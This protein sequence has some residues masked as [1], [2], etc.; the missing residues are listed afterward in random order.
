MTKANKDNLSLEQYIEA[1]NNETEP[2]KKAE[3]RF[4][5]KLIY[6][7]DIGESISDQLETNTNEPI[8]VT[9]LKSAMRQFNGTQ[10]TNHVYLGDNSIIELKQPEVGMILNIY[11]P[12]NKYRIISIEGDN[13][14]IA[15]VEDD[16]KGMN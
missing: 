4:D 8:H 10:W 12:K 7:L 16:Q 3:I 9:K 6:N 11:L 13:L 14:T 15:P 1:Y 5:A 2:L